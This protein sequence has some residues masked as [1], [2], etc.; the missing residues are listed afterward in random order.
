MLCVL[1]YQ[2][3]FCVMFVYVLQ[4]IILTTKN[5]T[6]HFLVV[7]L[8]I[9]IYILYDIEKKI[10]FVNSEKKRRKTRN[11]VVYRERSNHSRRKSESEREQNSS[12]VCFF[13][14]LSMDFFFFGSWLSDS[15]FLISASLLFY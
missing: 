3:V 15:G 8:N 7:G 14:F 6:N 1:L 9:L 2:I 13:L 4:N 12:G 5:F 11:S 10:E